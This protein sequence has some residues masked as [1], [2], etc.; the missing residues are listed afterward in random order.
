MVAA[1]VTQ[2]AEANGLLPDEQMGNRAHR[3]TELA[4]RLVVAQVQE[5]WR[6]KATASLL[7]LDISGAFDTVNHIRL[8]ATLRDMGFPRWLVLWTKDWLTSREATL[9][10]DGQTAPPTAIRAGVPQGSPLSPVLFILYIASLYSLLKEKHPHL[11][12]AGFADDTN[13]MVFGREPKANVRQLEAAWAT[14]LQ[15]AGTRGMAFAPEKSELIHF[16]KGRKQWTDRLDLAQPGRG[17]S[18]VNPT[19]SARFLGVWLDWKLNWKAYLRAVERKLTTQSYALS[20]I[21]AK[22][23]G[24]GLAKAREVYSKCIRS[25]LAYG[26][27]SFHI[28]TKKGAGPATRGITKALGKAQNNSLRIVAGAFESTPIRNLETETWVPPLD[29]YFNK[30]LADFEARLQMHALDDGRGGK[31]A[32]GSIVRTACDKLYRRFSTRRSSRGRPQAHGPQGPTAVEEA[33]I[34]ITSWTGGTADTDRIVEEA[35]KERWLKERE[36]RA[37]TRPADDFDHQQETLFKDKT[38]RRHE[39]LN[40]AQSSLLVQIRTGAIG[41]RVFLYS[42]GVPEVLTPSCECGEGRETV[43][44]LVMWCL[45]PPL[46]RRWERAELR[47][48]RDFYSVLQ[49][50]SPPAARLARRILGWLMDSGKLPMYNLARRLEL[51]VAV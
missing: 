32:A 22:T 31:K 26:A 41:L 46:P 4:V 24:L 42:R 12:I 7:Q 49:G 25:A 16:N 5:A 40:K 10:F 34:T 8:L 20:R 14:C 21:A 1:K 51:E 9:H 27:S 45:A 19:A 39:G 36:G 38:L 13:L 35:W 29:L 43:E 17:T 3:S 44:H 18:P 37:V 15:W 50:I 2:A 11:A 23:W 6:Q 48:R 30:R 28:P 47:T 33:A